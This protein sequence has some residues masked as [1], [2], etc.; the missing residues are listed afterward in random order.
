MF[1]GSGLIDTHCHFDF[2]EFDGCRDA[3][4][5]RCNSEGV[6][7]LLVPA[8]TQASWEPLLKMSGATPVVVRLA[9]GL[10]P[11]FIGSHQESDLV[12]LERFLASN[13]KASV[14]AV[15]EVGL[16]A[17]VSDYSR[18]EYFFDCQL[19]LATRF[20]LPVIVHSRKTHSAVCKKIKVSGVSSGVVHAF[21]GSRQEADAFVA[22]GL[23]LG[24]G[25]VITWPRATKTKAALSDAPLESLVLETDSPDM[26]I[27][28]KAK[29]QGSPL[30]VVEV[31]HA[32]CEIRS[33][34]P[35]Q[36]SHQ[37][38]QNSAKLFGCESWL[39]NGI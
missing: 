10:H 6:I 39:K 33:E 29:G 28:N 1:A 23:S 16:D 19:E 15:G 26:P 36:I 35:E 2:P 20:S 38:A 37:L 18:Q 4:L 34:S 11:Y 27:F 7:G 8:V 32:L 13:E 17:T 5:A 21:S 25:P 14:V 12:E 9:L 22:Q 24:V 31:F 3:L 30:D